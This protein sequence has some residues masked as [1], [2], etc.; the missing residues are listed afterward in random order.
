MITLN[1][2]DKIMVTEPLEQVVELAIQ[3]HRQIRAL[4]P[5]LPVN[6]RPLMADMNY[7]RLTEK[8]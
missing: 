7:D 6:L 2:G 8:R 1:T 5:W 4:C 3:Y